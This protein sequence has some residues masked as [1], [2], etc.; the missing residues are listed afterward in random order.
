VR[1]LTPLRSKIRRRNHVVF[2]DS[3]RLVA[4]SVFDAALCPRSISH[5]PHA[6]EHDPSAC[7]GQLL[8]V[9][10]LEASMKKYVSLLCSVMVVVFITWGGF[11]LPHLFKFSLTNS[12]Y[13]K[14]DIPRQVNDRFIAYGSFSTTGV[15]IR[16]YTDQYDEFHMRRILVVPADDRYNPSNYEVH[17]D[18]G[19]YMVH[20]GGKPI[21]FSLLSYI[22]NKTDDYDV[23]DNVKVSGKFG[24]ITTKFGSTTSLP[25]VGLF[26]INRE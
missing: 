9:G 12:S 11:S 4:S 23:G 8:I 24:E 7:G 6:D 19:I 3:G 10:L 5:N 15:V 2:H 20:I 17:T 16:T 1:A 13:S 22:H 26:V 18:R 14:Y 21:K 25:D